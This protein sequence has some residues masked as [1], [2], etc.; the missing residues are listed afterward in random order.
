MYVN[1]YIHLNIRGWGREHREAKRILLRH[2][3]CDLISIN[4]TWFK[5]DNDDLGVTGYR[6]FGHNRQLLNER[7]IK[8][9]GGVGVLVSNDIFSM[10]DVD[11]LDKYLNG[12]LALSLCNKVT[13]YKL[14]FITA[15]LPPDNSIYGRDPT[16][17]FSH[18]TNMIYMY[19][20]YDAIYIAGW[21]YSKPQCNWSGG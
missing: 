9:S 16:A 8:G 4:E 19:N 7:A 21:R 11:I 13:N 12:M 20:D 15:Y 10:Y 6:W 2:Y 1:T 17:F 5:E 18:L 14:I 3:D